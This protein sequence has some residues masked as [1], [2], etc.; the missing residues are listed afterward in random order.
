MN[1]QACLPEFWRIRL[2]LPDEQPATRLDRIDS[3]GIIFDNTN[4]IFIFRTVGAEV[5]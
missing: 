2:P 4:K 3:A 5:L 1:D